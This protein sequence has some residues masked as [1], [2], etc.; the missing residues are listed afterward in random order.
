MFLINNKN[1]AERFNKKT[2]SETDI[3]FFLPGFY[4]FLIVN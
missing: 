1:Y 4:L 3:N 2:V